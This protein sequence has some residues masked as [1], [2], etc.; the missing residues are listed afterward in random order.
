MEWAGQSVADKL[1]SLR[2]QLAEAG[3]GALLVTM[4]GAS[5]AGL[6]CLPAAPVPSRWRGPTC[7]APA[8]GAACQRAARCLP[9][10]AAGWGHPCGLAWLLCLSP[11]WL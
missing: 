11:V 7:D 2:R 5:G 3:A 8:A 9:G 6:P 10:R 4:L 1:A